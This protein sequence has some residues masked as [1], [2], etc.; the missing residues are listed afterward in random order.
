MSLCQSSFSGWNNSE[1]TSDVV[2]WEIQLRLISV[3]YFTCKHGIRQVI[4]LRE[5]NRPLN[6]RQCANCMLYFK[7][8]LASSI[9]YCRTIL[10][11][12]WLKHLY[13]TPNTFQKYFPITDFVKNRFKQHSTLTALTVVC[14]NYK[15]RALAY[16]LF[17]L[18]RL[19][20]PLFS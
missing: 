6:R 13:F 20:G 9:V 8:L 14:V 7:I 2:T 19:E 15:P 17:D 4:T 12:F 1:L 3:F 18:S 10:N 11:T 5:M 16:R